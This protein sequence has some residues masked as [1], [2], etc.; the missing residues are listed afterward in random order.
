VIPA[1]LLERVAGAPISWGVCEAPGWGV[2]IGPDRFLTELTGLG[3]TATELGPPGFLPGDPAALRARLDRYGVRLVGAFCAAV[4]HTGGLPAAVAETVA[5][6]EPA[7]AGH[8]LLSADTDRPGYDGRAELDEAGW[9]RLLRNL[10]AAAERARGHG[11]TASLH[12]HAGTMIERRGEIERLLSD[13]AIP[14]CLDTGHV[15]IGGADPVAIA[16]AH[17]DRVVHVHLKDVDAGLARQVL[18]GEIPYQL[19]VRA[20]LYRP[21]GK[22]D[23]DV[24]GTVAALEDAGYRGWYVLEQ[25]VA[26]DTEPPPGEGPVADVRASLEYLRGLAG[27]G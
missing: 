6:L 15:A 5:T 9:E 1:D 16:R 21:L 10:D 12:P 2:Q 7:G 24:A 20:G 4:L 27:S 22:G 26:L 19:A 3:L 13:S 25:D 18:N 8:L 14:L 11:V 17:P 23:V